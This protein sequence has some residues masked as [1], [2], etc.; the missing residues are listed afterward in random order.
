[1]GGGA[2]VWSICLLDMFV[3]FFYCL[4]FFLVAKVCL[5]YEWISSLNIHV[6]K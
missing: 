1:M 5:L 3:M 2:C 4:F 6:A